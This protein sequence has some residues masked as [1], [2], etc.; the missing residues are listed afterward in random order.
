MASILISVVNSSTLLTDMITASHELLEML[1]R[2]KSAPFPM[3][4]RRTKGGD[5]AR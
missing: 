3:E 4:G 1:P 2:G 5:Y